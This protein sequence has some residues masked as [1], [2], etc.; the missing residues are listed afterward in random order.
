MKTAVAYVDRAGII[1]FALDREQP[2][3]VFVFARH[4]SLAD[5][6]MIVEAAAGRTYDWST[7]IVPGMPEAKDDADALVCVEEWRDREFADY[8]IR[9]GVALITDDAPAAIEGVA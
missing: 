2:L 7:L 1:G 9:N 5:L 3:G 8:T 4:R 6:A